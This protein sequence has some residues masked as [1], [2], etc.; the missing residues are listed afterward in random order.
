MLLAVRLKWRRSVVIGQSRSVSKVRFVCNV[1][2]MDES[3]VWC[4]YWLTPV[5]GN[6]FQVSK[7]DFQGQAL[8]VV[9]AVG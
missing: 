8:K 3:F 1:N 4:R 7:P 2:V 6:L 5:E 9:G